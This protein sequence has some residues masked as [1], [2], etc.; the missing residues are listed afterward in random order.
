MI[1]HRRH[2]WVKLRVKEYDNLDQ[3]AKCGI[4]RKQGANIA[5]GGPSSYYC[6]YIIDGVMQDDRPECRDIYGSHEWAWDGHSPH[7]SCVCGVGRLAVQIPCGPKLQFYRR[8]GAAFA[9]DREW[10]NEYIAHET[11]V[12]EKK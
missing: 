4:K 3:C 2:A 1:W 12:E 10:I 5:R 7:A 11:K 8:R 6:R 9:E